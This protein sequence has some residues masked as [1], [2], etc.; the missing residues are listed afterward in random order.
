MTVKNINLS[1]QQLSTIVAQAVA[2][3]LA[4]VQ[5]TE[6][7]KAETK[8]VEEVKQPQEPVLSEEPKEPKR[9]YAGGK[10]FPLDNIRIAER[11]LTSDGYRYE[12][13][14]TKSGLLGLYVKGSLIMTYHK[15]TGVFRKFVEKSFNQL[16]KAQQSCV[17][18]FVHTN[19]VRY[20]AENS[21]ESAYLGY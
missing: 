5:K 16:S 7:P 20:V 18:A 12:V 17:T 15:R 8:P 3:A 11:G 13:L 4:S 2:Q 9:F 14:S 21:W 6:E 1:E 10:F 19:N